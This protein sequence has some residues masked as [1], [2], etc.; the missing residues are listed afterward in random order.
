MREEMTFKLSKPIKVS[1]DGQFEETH[2]LRLTAPSFKD[3]K[4]AG[5]LEQSVVR[6]MM[7]VT[8]KNTG[9]KPE[10]GDGGDAEIDKDAIRFLLMSSSQDIDAVYDIFATLCKRV[11]T[12][13]DGVNMTDNLLEQIDYHDFQ[14]LCFEYIANFTIQSLTLGKS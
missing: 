7:D 3:R 9:A 1:K 14:S 11:C 12:V 6:A 13:I 10:E 8:D 5:K 2:E 4:Q